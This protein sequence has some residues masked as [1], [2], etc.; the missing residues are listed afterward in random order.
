MQGASIQ[1]GCTSRE[2][3][4]LSA[5][6]RRSVIQTK[7][8]LINFREN[9]TDLLDTLGRVL[10]H[11]NKTS[12]DIDFIEAV[13]SYKSGLESSINTAAYL[14]GKLRRPELSQWLET[15][16]DRVIAA[17]PAGEQALVR[18]AF[19]CAAESLIALQQSTSPH[20]SP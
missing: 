3:L 1:S 6:L 11:L 15:N 9:L 10:T 20:R 19:A 4:D 7:D 12:S 2:P 16:G 14:P 13:L 17:M 18:N 5:P 8:P